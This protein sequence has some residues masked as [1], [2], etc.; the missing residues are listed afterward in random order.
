LKNIKVSLL[1]FEGP[2]KVAHCINN[3]NNNNNNNIKIDINTNNDPLLETIWEHMKEV[4]EREV[5]L[6][7]FKL[8]SFLSLFL[9]FSSHFQSET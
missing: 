5:I 1:C 2:I 6:L 7:N 3:N 4:R 8:S 9:F